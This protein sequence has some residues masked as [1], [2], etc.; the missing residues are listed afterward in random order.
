MKGCEDV[1]PWAG[2]PRGQM[3][4]SDE[5]EAFGPADRQVV[6]WAGAAFPLTQGRNM[7]SCRLVSCP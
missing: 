3:M 4:K 2:R 5:V 1:G 7:Y 6:D